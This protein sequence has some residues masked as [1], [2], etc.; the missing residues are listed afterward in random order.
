M[1]ANPLAFYPN[2]S[3]PGGADEILFQTEDCKIVVK[4]EVPNFENKLAISKSE[5]TASLSS[6]K[7][8]PNPAKEKVRISYNTGSE[9]LQAK[10]ITIFDA[11]GNIK[12]RKELKASSGEVDVEVSSWLQSVYIVIVQTGDTSLQGKLIK[13]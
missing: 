8:A 7:I 4:V 1:S 13:N 2:N 11:R 12:F 9:K 5:S 10:Q 3:F 6:L